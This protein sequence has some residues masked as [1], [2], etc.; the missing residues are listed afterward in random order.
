VSGTLT[1]L[2]GLDVDVEEFLGAVLEATAQPIWVVGPDGLIRYANAAAI[3][4]LGDG[5][6]EELLG[7]HS[8]ETVQPSTASSASTAQPTAARSSPRTSPSPLARSAGVDEVVELRASSRPA[9]DDR[10]GTLLT[11]RSRTYW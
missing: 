1:D 5:R 8:H 9:R 11:S 2:A 6:A 10:D 3:A 4:T 7:R